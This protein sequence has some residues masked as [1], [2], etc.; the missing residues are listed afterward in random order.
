VQW[1]GRKGIRVV[2][3]APGFFPSEITDQVRAPR[4]MRASIS[5]GA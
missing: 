4:R 3:L 1:T 5:V 2:A